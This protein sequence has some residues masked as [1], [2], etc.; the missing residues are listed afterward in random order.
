MSII[1]EDKAYAKIMMH[2]MK[3]TTKDCIGV[4]IGTEEEENK[5]KVSDAIPLF[6]ERLFAPQLEIALKFVK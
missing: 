1:I 2:I 6:H 4:L 5:I 3:H